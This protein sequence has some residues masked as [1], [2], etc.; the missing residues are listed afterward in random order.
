MQM[1]TKHVDVAFSIVSAASSSSFV[2]V[3]KCPFVL[4]LVSSWIAS[5]SV[6]FATL[7]QAY[8]FWHF[9]QCFVVT[10]FL[11][12]SC[13]I[14]LCVTAEPSSQLLS[15]FLVIL[16]YDPACLFGFHHSYSFGTLAL[17]VF[18]IWPL[19]FPGYSFDVLYFCLVGLSV[20]CVTNFFLY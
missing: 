5:V 4:L 11:V 6:R 2:V 20:H 12:Y 14:V 7:S 17:S 1:W 15:V 9:S 10:P 8:L 3:W 16:V 13:Q 19:L 18:V